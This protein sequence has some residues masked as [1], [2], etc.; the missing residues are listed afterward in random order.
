M[1]YTKDCLLKT[2]KK[3]EEIKGKIV[4]FKTFRD[5]LIDELGKN[6]PDEYKE[7]SRIREEESKERQASDATSEAITSTN[8]GKELK[9]EIE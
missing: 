4:T 1:L 6:F 9:K 7:Y 5:Q 3:N 8:I 2:L